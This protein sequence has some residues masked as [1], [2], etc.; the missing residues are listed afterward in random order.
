M[1][2]RIDPTV[3]LFA[4]LDE[5]CHAA[6]RVLENRLRSLGLS[7]MKVGILFCLR[8][9]PEPKT[10]AN[11]SRWLFREPNTIFSQL[12]E[13]EKLGLVRRIKDLDRRNMVRVELTE[14]G[15]EMYHQ[16]RP[17]VEVFREM[18]SCLSEEQQACLAECLDLLRRK[19]LSQLAL[20]KD[21]LSMW[22]QSA[23]YSRDEST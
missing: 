8:Q 22:P 9:M 15:E 23:Y 7:M 13:M 14:K 10:P 5:S 2:I 18:M 17:N 4:L 11:L 3:V 19:A 16:A 12:K 20:V 1:N 21:P 6:T